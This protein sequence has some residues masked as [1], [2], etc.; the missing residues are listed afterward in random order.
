[1]EKIRKK[2]LWIRIC[3]VFFL[4]F[5][6]LAYLYLRN[7]VRKE[8]LIY[9]RYPEYPDLRI[10]LSGESHNLLLITVDTLRPDYLSFNGYDLDTSPAVDRLISRGLYF[11]H[12]ITP[13]P[14][15]TQALACLLTGCYP[16]KT[17][18]RYLWDNLSTKTVTLTDI[19][20]RSNYETIAVVSNHVLLP[21]R[22]LDRGFGVYDFGTDKRD[23][24]QTTQAAI[25]Y[26]NTLDLERPFFLWVHYI[27]PHAPYYPPEDI[28]LRF[29]PDYNGRYKTHFGDEP[30]G[31]GEYAYPK[32]IGKERAVFRNDLGEEINQHV[33]RLYAADIRLTD[34]G[35]EQLVQ[36]V[37][38]VAGDNLL[39]VFTADHGESLG[40][41]D[42]YFDH[43]AYVYNAGLRVPLAFVLPEGH[44]KYWIGAEDDWVSLVD[45]LPTTLDLMGI[46]VQSHHLNGIDGRSLLPYWEK[47][48]L[49]PRPFFAESGRSFFQD[50]IKRRVK[51]DVSGRFRCVFFNNLKLIWT[52]YQKNELLYEL[53]DMESDPSETEDLFSQDS[54]E[55]EMLKDFLYQWMAQQPQ[56]ALETRPTEKDLEILRSLGYVSEKKTKKKPK[57]KK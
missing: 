31:I 54:Q 50:S 28:A 9:P 8:E 1:M 52:P 47:T 44:S 36:A 12:A 20:K 19:L 40:E 45:I 6:F 14:R 37:E 25:Q 3:A 21:S 23:A 56:E 41:H 17:Q 55:R 11:S 43:G 39:I 7:Y 53:Y 35:I 22:G 18:V 29:D 15:T 51:F 57:E 32:D 13:I 4:L 30:G 24:I 46:E 16:Y 42:Y 38:R 34:L 2:R 33:R 48:P 5:A 27:D 49:E 10:K 26:L